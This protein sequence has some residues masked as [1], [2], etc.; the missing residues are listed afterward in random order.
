MLKGKEWP[1]QYLLL[2]QESDCTKG[3]LAITV[4]G[5]LTVQIS[6][7]KE[8]TIINILNW[9]FPYTLSKFWSTSRTKSFLLGVAGMVFVNG[10][11]LGLRLSNW[12]QL[13]GLQRSVQV[14]S[15]CQNER[16]QRKTSYLIGTYVYW[17]L[18]RREGQGDEEAGDSEA[19][20][21]SH[22]RFS[23]YSLY[24]TVNEPLL[25]VVSIF[26]ASAAMA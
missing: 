10:K 15:T 5:I 20:M 19:F 8:Q 14:S 1:Q 26:R 23:F 11:F 3:I 4:K 6:S 9:I 7:Q 21:K 16:A 25:Q 22:L 2:V 17:Y 12:P 24:F 13:F 18:A